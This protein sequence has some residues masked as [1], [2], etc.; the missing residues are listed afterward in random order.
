ML[1]INNEQPPEEFLLPF[2]DEFVQRRHQELE[3]LRDANASSDFP[4]VKKIAHNWA[5][6]S[7]PY[8]FGA[9]A[10]VARDLERL[11]EEQNGAQISEL[12]GEIKTYLEKKQSQI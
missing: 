12:I 2:L 11:A 8:G 10:D 9:L 5:G 4:V 1:D 3:E 6:V 7:A